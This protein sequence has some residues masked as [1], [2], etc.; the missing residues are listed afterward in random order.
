MS[1]QPA[2][3]N[4]IK[5]ERPVLV[6][7]TGSRA[8][9]FPALP[10]S[11][12]LSAFLLLAAAGAGTGIAASQLDA[13]QAVLHA[14]DFHTRQQ[15]ASQ[16]GHN[17]ALDAEAIEALIGL[18]ELPSI[19]DLDSSE[20]VA[21]KDI[22]CTVL[23]NQTLYPAQLPD[24]LIAMFHD[25]RHA[26]AWRDYCIQ[27]LNTACNKIPAD[28]RPRIYEIFWQATAETGSTI[29]G[30]ALIALAD[31][32]ADPAISLEEVQHK[33]VHIATDPAAS[34]ASRLT[35][36]QI[37][38]ELG[39]PRVLP[40]A[41]NLARDPSAERPLRLSAIAAIGILGT[42]EDLPLLQELS[43]ASGH[44]PGVAARTAHTKLQARYPKTGNETKTLHHNL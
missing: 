5:R 8:P 2:I 23:E 37:A 30:T 24:R 26:A 28:Q 36:I 20:T 9:R 13:L 40:T 43:S 33:A 31:H 16:I 12:L 3:P 1:N 41:R 11:V 19:P 18:L 14:E 44:V 25:T 6:Q 10:A 38:A 4:L 39:D 27:H 42:R 17:L 29:A 35:A 22:V 34:S 21:L 32:R 7:H 15:A